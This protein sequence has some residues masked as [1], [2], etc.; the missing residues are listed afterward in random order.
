[1]AFWNM[2]PFNDSL[3]NDGETWIIEGR[4]THAY[5]AVSVRDGSVATAAA[6]LRSVM[7][8][9]TKEEPPESQ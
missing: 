6:R 9:L 2:P 8:S 1:V 7:L 5:H 3:V 4:R